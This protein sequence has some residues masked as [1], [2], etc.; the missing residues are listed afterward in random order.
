MLIL[1]VGVA[2][3][4][5]LS[6]SQVK[7]S[8]LPQWLDVETFSDLKFLLWETIL[9]ALVIVGLS[10]LISNFEHMRWSALVIPGAI[11][12]LSLSL[13]FMKRSDTK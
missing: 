6:T 13:Y 11:L 5:L 10:S 7:T 3:L 8:S 12:M 9:L 1:A 4:F 2:K